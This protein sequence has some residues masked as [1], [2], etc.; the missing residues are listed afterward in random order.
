MD[1][2]GAQRL[3]GH[4][5]DGWKIVGR[6]DS[7]PESTGG[8][9]SVG[10]LVEHESGE[11]GFLK[12]LDFE[13]ALGEPDPA[14]VLEF[15]TA[16]FN[17]ERMLLERCGTSNLTKIVKVR[18]SGT[19]RLDEDTPP[20]QYLILELAEA[21]IRAHVDAMQGLDAVLLMNALHDVA[22]GLQQLHNNRMAHLDVKP[23]NVLVFAPTL[24][25]IGDLGRGLHRS[26]PA[27]YQ[28]EVIVGD[29]SHA[30]PELLYGEIDPDWQKRHHACDAYLLGSLTMFLFCGVSTTPMLLSR[31]SKQHQPEVWPYGYREVLPLV[32]EVFGQI[33]LEAEG[34]LHVD[35]RQ[36]IAGTV[37]E[38]CE[39]DPSVRGHPRNRAGAQLDQYGLE[40]YVAQFNLL[41]HRA[42]LRLLTSLRE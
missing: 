12:A 17:Y 37:R 3:H 10:Y 36:S 39:P 30:P 42:E 4:V 19:V 20:V 31:I 1:L 23:S 21:D 38:L 9:F 18:S 24:T 5:D 11:R 35:I 14:G 15:L 27:P 33:M 2:T 34:S 7:D 13:R 16:S 28:E 22:L 29:P 26:S 41:A 40:R 32:R 8:N 25:K 6:I